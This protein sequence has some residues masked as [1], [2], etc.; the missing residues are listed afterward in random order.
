M[1]L[2]PKDIHREVLKRDE[3]PHG[4]EPSWYAVWYGLPHAEGAELLGRTERLARPRWWRA[5]PAD[6]TYPK[7]IRGWSNIIAWFIELKARE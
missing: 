1:R 3:R 4:G 2:T 6:G 5:Y 7:E